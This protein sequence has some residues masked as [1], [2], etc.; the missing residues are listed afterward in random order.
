MD[1]RQFTLQLYDGK[2]PP[3]PGYVQPMSS[4][5]LADVAPR[6]RCS[7]CLMAWG[8]YGATTADGR[9]E[10]HGC[11]LCGMLEKW[12]AD[13]PGAR[14]IDNRVGIDTSSDYHTLHPAAPYAIASVERAITEGHFHRLTFACQPNIA[15]RVRIAVDFTMKHWMRLHERGQI[16]HPIDTDF[17]IRHDIA[18]MHVHVR[19]GLTGQPAK[20][21]DRFTVRYRWVQ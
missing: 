5:E 7:G 3:M 13:S 2:L 21:C 19:M 10:G 18:T 14:M 16:L 8:V 4:P 11:L 12:V 6:W 9:P 1:R 15:T 17:L 20:Q